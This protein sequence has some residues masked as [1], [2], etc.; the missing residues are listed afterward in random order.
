MQMLHAILA[1][2]KR[3]IAMLGGG[4]WTQ[5]AV[6]D[7]RAFVEANNLPVCASFRSVDLLDNDHP[8]YIGETSAGGAAPPLP[9]R[10]RE[11][12]DVLLVVGA[13][14]G[15]FSTHGYTLVVPPR[16]RQ[17]LVHVYADPD[18][19]GR[20]YQGELSIA[21]GMEEFAS[22]ARALSAI[23]R[24]PWDDWTRAEIGRASCRERV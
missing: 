8:N 5:K 16:P 3:P 18:E 13:R 12:C 4:G 14:L 7:I 10:I 23:E 6:D 22:A 24:R 9:K 15:E 11:D 17:R 19:L 20:V 2:A 1:G 21:S